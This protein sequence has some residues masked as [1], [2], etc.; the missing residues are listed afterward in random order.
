MIAALIAL[1]AVQ[2]PTW[3]QPR[4]ELADGKSLGGI[5]FGEDTDGTLKRRFRT[6]R[7]AI[8]PEG[9]VL[10]Q[11]QDKGLKVDALL[12]GRGKDAPVIGIR[13]QFLRFAPTRETFEKEL[14]GET[15]TFF[16]RN[17]YS[18]WAVLTNEEKGIAA[19]AVRERN[20]TVMESLV[21]TTPARIR[22]L[23][24]GLSSGAGDI[25]DLQREF[26]R[27]DRTVKVRST[28]V[29]MTA[30]NITTPD[31]NR[32]SRDL[33]RYADRQFE[34]RVLRYGGDGSISISISLD[35]DK[36]SVSASLNAKNEAGTVSASASKSGR[37]RE[38]NDIAYY[39][40]GV[41]QNLVEGVLDELSDNAER[42]VENQRPQT[43]SE[44]RNKAVL[45][46]INRAIR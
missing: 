34:S 42:A 28:S 40:R 9:L 25:G 20:D 12:A 6:D 38:A 15:E 24:R 17:R 30:K 10:A 31:R 44:E 41:I 35:F 3:E 21:F 19:F 11:S 33:E 2:N 37:F 1:A 18:D 23:T 7:G 45:D 8:R 39:D 26:D 13:L 46:L 14:G 16:A 43:E 5:I 27:L 4:F 32:E 36:V 22:E 29:T